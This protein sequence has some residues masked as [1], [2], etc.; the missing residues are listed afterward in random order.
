VPIGNFF[1]AARAATSRDTAAKSRNAQ[2]LM[3]MSTRGRARADAARGEQFKG[4]PSSLRSL[5][6]D[7]LYRTAGTKNRGKHPKKY[8]VSRSFRLAMSQAMVSAAMRVSRK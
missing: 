5:F 3:C 7:G 8:G 6:R 2:S 1:S 4:Y